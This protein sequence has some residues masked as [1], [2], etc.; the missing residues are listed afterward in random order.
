MRYERLD[1]KGYRP[2]L[3]EDIDFP[4]KQLDGDLDI[5]VIGGKTGSGKT[6]I[7][8]A[9]VH[10]WRGTRQWVGLRPRGPLMLG[11]WRWID[12]NESDPCYPGARE[13]DFIQPEAL[14]LLDRLLLEYTSFRRTGA[15]YTKDSWSHPFPVICQHTNHHREPVEFRH[16]GLGAVSFITT[17]M[18]IWQA[19]LQ[20]PCLVLV[21]EPELHLNAWLQQRFVRELERI[22]PH[23]QYVLATNSEEVFASVRP[24]QRLM[25]YDDVE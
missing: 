17:L 12:Q 1:V 14:E 11:S 16:I 9:V 2:W 13:V 18:T 6:T 7:L 22:A 15:P 4:K 24:H 19:T 23:N 21:D 3:D 5:L 8:D 10:R 25:L 20:A